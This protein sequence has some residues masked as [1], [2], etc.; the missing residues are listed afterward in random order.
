MDCTGEMAPPDV[1][2]PP[3]NNLRLRLSGMLAW[4]YLYTPPGNVEILWGM[5]NFL[6]ADS[7]LTILGER[8]DDLLEILCLFRADGRPTLLEESIVASC[9]SLRGVEISWLHSSAGHTLVPWWIAQLDC[10]NNSYCPSFC[11][12]RRPV[13]VLEDC[14]FDKSPSGRQ[15]TR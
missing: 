15:V 4:E 10:L 11:G 9:L 12:R 7:R 8:V 14:R 2:I 1:C 13:E 5:S 3:G 6:K